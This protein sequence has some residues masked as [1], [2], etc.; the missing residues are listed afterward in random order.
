MS[1]TFLAGT[2]YD[3]YVGTAAFDTHGGTDLH[4]MFAKHC[5]G[6]GGYFP[7][8]LELGMIAPDSLDGKITV[9][10]L[11]LKKADYGD[12]MEE[13]IRSTSTAERV[14]LHRF[15]AVIPIGHFNAFF[16][17]MDIKAV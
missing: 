1:E 15:D 8:G 11:A 9:T 6:N 4:T 17:R 14:T 12:T 5:P 10:I 16:K 2:Q 7:V 3:D 13:I